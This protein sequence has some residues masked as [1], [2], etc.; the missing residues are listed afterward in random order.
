M[1]NTQDARRNTH[2][3]ICSAALCY[4]VLALVYLWPS[5][6]SGAVPLPLTNPYTW[7]DP[8]WA[9]YAPPDVAVG[10]NRLLGDISGFYYPY[11]VFNIASIQRGEFALW[12]P[13]LFGGTP[14]FAANQAAQLYP[15][16]L[17]VYWLGPHHFWTAGALLRMTIAGL[18]MFLFVRRLGANWLG[19]LLAGGIYEF[20]AF[21]IVWLHFAIHNVAAL[22]PL[23]LW[24]ILHV[25]G[26]QSRVAALSLTGVIAAQMLGGHPEMSLFF[27]VACMLFAGA[28]LFGKTTTDKRRTTADDRWATKDEGRPTT[29][30]RRPANDD[31]PPMRDD[32]RDLVT[33]SPLHPFTRSPLRPF[34]R[35]PLHP[36]TPSP[37]RPY[38]RAA[39]MIALAFTLGL[40]LAA[41]QWLP[42][43]DLIHT[44]YTLE[45]RDFAAEQSDVNVPNYAPLGGLQRAEWGNLRH[46]LLLVVPELWGSPRGEQINYWLPK[47]NY[48]EMASYVGLVTL[49][50]VA[51]GLRHH[52][53]RATWLFGGVFLLSLLLLYPLPGLR[54]IGFLPLFDVAYGFRFGLGITLAACVLAGLGLTVLCRIGTRTRWTMAMACIALA[55]L[56]FA[57]VYDLWGGARVDWALGATP[58]ETTHGQIAAVF[59]ANHWRPVLPGIAGLAAGLLLIGA[60]M[61]QRISPSN[62]ATP[63]AVT[64]VAG[65]AVVELIVHGYGYNGFTRP[66]VIYPR[67]LT[68][69][70][71][72]GCRG[73]ACIAPTNDMFRVLPLDNTLWANTGMTQGLHVTGGMDDLV[74]GEQYRFIGRGMSAIVSFGDRHV[75]LDWSRRLMDVM[76]VRYVLSRHPIALGPHGPELPLALQDGALRV[77]R[78]ENPLPRAYAVTTA[79]QADSSDAQ[80]VVFSAEFDPRR[81]VVLETQPAFPLR[82]DYAPVQ[83]VAITTYT[84]DYVAL[85]ANVAEPAVVVLADSFDLDWR[86][87]INGQEAPLLRT[88]GMFRGVVVSAGRHRIEFSYQPRIL[89]WSGII[90]GMALV[91]CVVWG[92]WRRR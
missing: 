25:L 21:N 75:A 70:Y 29:D 49:P 13:Y 74:D 43:L 41:V 90:S 81:S 65:L 76:N 38:S 84:P 67:T 36:F 27:M 50:L 14:F 59:G 35:S 55:G 1:N 53:R 20:A 60:A 23:A 64:L 68:I 78:N 71:M 7:V 54:L 33:P 11:Q 80:D 48:N 6:W 5:L 18:G 69:D 47:T 2:Y 12:N 56:N 83:P 31:R 40:G 15:I 89:L 66:E 86:V 77:Y 42:T 63:V 85:D 28:W 45:D 46:W 9:N 57:I 8:V 4:F 22:L 3:A 17:L 82:G 37:L 62:R 32:Q 16:N 87:R 52:N 73:E 51:L 91:G 34:T 88:N 26:S 61:K 58:N 24:L 44:S 10:S 79:I 30:D 19:A 39:S 72:H 92:M